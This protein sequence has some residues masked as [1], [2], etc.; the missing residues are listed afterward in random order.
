MEIAL[1]NKKKFKEYFLSY[2]MNI[3]FKN[4]WLFLLRA[5]M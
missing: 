5:F 2:F 4:I 3:N 1:F